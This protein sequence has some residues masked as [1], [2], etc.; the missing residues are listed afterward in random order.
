MASERR[1]NSRVNV[2]L[3]VNIRLSDGH[4][5][6]S[7][8]IRNISLGGVFI[9]MPEPLAFGTEIYLEFKLPETPRILNCSGFVVWS[10]KTNPERCPGKI[11]IGVRLMDISINEIRLLHEF[12]DGQVA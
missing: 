11:G 8:L 7:N 12:I 10:S 1:S 6:S 2:K 3:S 4:S 9:E 5:L